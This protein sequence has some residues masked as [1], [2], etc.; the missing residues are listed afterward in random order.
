MKFKEGLLKAR[1]HIIFLLGL[2]AAFGI[3]ITLEQLKLQKIMR[4]GIQIK[5]SPDIPSPSSRRPLTEEEKK[6]ALIAWKYFENNFNPE[7]GMVNSVDQYPAST[8]WD[9]ASYLMALISAHRL[10]I[11]D[12]EAFD[13]RLS[14]LL[15]TLANIPLFEGKLPNKSYNTIKAEMVNYQNQKSEKGIGWSAI[16]I[17]RLLTPFNVIVWNYPRHT[18]EV[19]QILSRWK[20]QAM[21][22][23]GLLF[24]AAV[25][26]DGKS[27]LVQEGRIGYEQYAAKSMSLMGMDVS[28]AL[29]YTD[30]L[31]FVEIYGIQVPYDNRDPEKYHAH[32]YVVSEPYI[33]D[34]IEFGWDEIS[35]EFAFRVYTAQEEKHRHT[36]ILTAVSEDNIDRS[37]YFVYNT[38]FTDGKIWNC[39]TEQGKDASEFKTLSTKAAFGW[40]M[41]YATSYTT[42]LMKKAAELYDPEK[43]WYSGFYHALKTVNK[44][45]TCNTNA[46]ILESLCYLKFG[47]MVAIYKSL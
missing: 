32:N 37:P 21:I 35:R 29:N 33:L 41:L 24:G 19:R 38:V 8:M 36:G 43:G 1:S 7:T 46:I 34:G 25:T 18:D 27:M 20:F 28:R 6:W 26:D 42:E 5:H 13:A 11:I 14:L 10:E 3:V 45:V 30:Y 23:N 17:G 4:P 40:H 12:T 22:H 16:D 9:T 44:A 39:I 31:S 15:R 47:K 2:I